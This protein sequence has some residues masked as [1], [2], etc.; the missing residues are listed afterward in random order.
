MM[1]S[2]D[3][4]QTKDMLVANIDRLTGMYRAVLHGVKNENWSGKGPGEYRALTPAELEERFKLK[5]P[6]E[7]PRRG[8][9]LFPKGPP[10]RGEINLDTTG[11]EIK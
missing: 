4:K 6:P 1:G 11:K 10:P 7:E 2:L 5:T 8:P 9:G 3:Q